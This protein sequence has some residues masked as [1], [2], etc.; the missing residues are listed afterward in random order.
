[1]RRLKL[2]ASKE[3]ALC[4][5]LFVSILGWEHAVCECH[6]EQKES[7]GSGGAQAA[8]RTHLWGKA[9]F[10]KMTRSSM[11]LALVGYSLLWEPMHILVKKKHLKIRFC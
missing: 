5:V 11:G 10:K 2:F 3:D 9:A 1:M 4:S 8:L 6:G 7:H